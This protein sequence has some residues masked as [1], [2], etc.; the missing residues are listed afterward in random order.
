[1]KYFKYQG[2]GVFDV[3]V[4]PFKCFVH[5]CIEGADMFMHRTVVFFVFSYS[6]KIIDRTNVRPLQDFSG[7]SICFTVD[8]WYEY[9]NYIIKN[10][11]IEPLSCAL[12]HQRFCII[13]AQPCT[14]RGIFIGD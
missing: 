10:L 5:L 12:R 2:L 11:I 1:M 8:T 6:Y 14:T 9:G 4:I 13:D 3:R 7:S